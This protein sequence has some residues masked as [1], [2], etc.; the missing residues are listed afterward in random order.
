M[1]KRGLPVISVRLEQN[2]KGKV[3]KIAEGERMFAGPWLEKY[4]IAHMIADGL[5][6]PDD[7]VDDEL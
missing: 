7:V 5:L 2:I 6:S 3:E 1:K 4:I